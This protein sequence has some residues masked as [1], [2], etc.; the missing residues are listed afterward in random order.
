MTRHMLNKL[1]ESSNIGAEYSVSSH[2][3]LMYKLLQE[4]KTGLLSSSGALVEI[5]HVC[6]CENLHDWKKNLKQ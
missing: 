1:D 5:H 4:N 2:L 6:V 3:Y